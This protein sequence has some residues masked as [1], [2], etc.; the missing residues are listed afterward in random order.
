MSGDEWKS[1][2]AFVNFMDKVISVRSYTL[3]TASLEPA[4]AVSQRVSKAP[5]PVCLSAQPHTT[6]P[7]PGA[8][9]C[10]RAA[11]HSCKNCARNVLQAQANQHTTC[12]AR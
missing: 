8:R 6:Q 1:E 12:A 11:L 10:R 4:F 9:P 7:G 3:P 5:P 2:T